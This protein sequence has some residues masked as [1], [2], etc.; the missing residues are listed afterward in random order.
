[1]KGLLTAI[2]TYWDATSALVTDIGPLGLNEIPPSTTGAYVV[3]S[4][5]ASPTSFNYG[6]TSFTE[7]TLQFTLRDSDSL[8]GLTKIEA[9]MALLDDKVFT[10]ASKQNFGFVREHDPL[11]EPADPEPDQEAR[12][13][14]GWIVT[15][16]AANTV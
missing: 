6:A 7:P 10:I 1:M 9:M 3:L 2:N 8:T 14:F 5:V 12:P 13:S 11:P 15:Y 4:V 16:R